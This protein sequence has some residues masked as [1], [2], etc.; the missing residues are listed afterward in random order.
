MCNSDI[1]VDPA[2]L[3][4]ESSDYASS[5]YET[6]TQSITSSV[7]QY[8]IENGRRYHSYFGLDKNPM[9]TDEAEQDRLDMHH[10]SFL[11]LLDGELHVAPIKEPH[12]ILDVGTGTGI[13]AIDAADRY[14]GAEV[15]GTDIS[16][17]QPG[18]VPP[19]CKFEIDDAEQEWTYRPDSFDFIHVRNFTFSCNSWPKFMASLYKHTTPGGYVELQ[20]LGG[21]LHSDD[22]TMSDD[23]AAKR[24]LELQVEAL[25]KM[26]R[27]THTGRTLKALFE[28]AGFEDVTVRDVKHPLGPWPKDKRLKHIGAMMLLNCATAFEA[29]GL[30]LFTR[31]LQLGHDEALQLCR[32]AFDAVKNRHNHTYTYFHVVYGRKPEH[33][34]PRSSPE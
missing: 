12:R 10:E 11:M 5:G 26:G 15:I 14:P 3:G 1:E 28:Q 16:P 7:H 9:P 29:Y 23:N 21:V 17:I 13:W 19:N 24:H 20:E 2:V 27:P 32:E 30:A 4:S 6:S 8:V 18:W 34:S 31:V 33:P 22:G 25:A